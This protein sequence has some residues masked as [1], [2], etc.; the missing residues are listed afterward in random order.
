VHF[1]RFP[2]SLVL[3]A[4]GGGEHAPTRFAALV[5]LAHILYSGGRPVAIDVTVRGIAMTIWL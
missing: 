4:Y 5:P 2:L 1:P 3:L